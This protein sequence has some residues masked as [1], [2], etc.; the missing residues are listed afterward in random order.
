MDCLLNK[1]VTAYGV[2][3]REEAVRQ[4]IREELLEVNCHIREDKMGNIIVK[5]GAGEEKIMFCAH[6]DQIGVIV[7][8]I[9]NSGIVRVGSVGDFKLVDM[10]HNFV[11]FSNGTVGKLCASKEN[12]TI[13]DMYIDLGL[14]SREEV[15]KLVKEGDTARFIMAYNTLGGKEIGPNFDDRIGCYVLLRMIKEFKESSKEVYFVFST[16]KELG[17][18]G[19]RAAAY[20]IEPDYCI[21][22]DVE[23]T[24]DVPGG[25]GS[26]KLGEGPVV[27]IINKTL[28]LDH[29]VKE[30]LDKAA[31]GAEIKL[32]Y[33]IS[34][35]NTDGGLIHKEVGGIKTGVVSI[36]CRYLHTVSEMISMDDVEKTIKVLN[37]LLK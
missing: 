14:N 36:P 12:P 20:A 30:M 19:A 21:V 13:E 33:S 37:N 4:V 11:E 2:S 27:S 28:I 15:L 5:L 35:E 34:T 22:V 1:L 9:E 23:G 6:M 17:G 29:E 32:Q 31:E 25:Q 8:Y 18:R 3:G 16:Q 7:T 24:G 10:I 26:L